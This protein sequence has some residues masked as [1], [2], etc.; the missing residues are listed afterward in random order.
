[1]RHD[2]ADRRPHRRLAGAVVACALLLAGCA[3]GTNPGAAP[4]TID[5]NT[6]ISTYVALRLAVIGPEPGTMNDSIRSAILARHG[7]TERQLEEFAKVH[8]SNVAYMRALWQDV[9]KRMRE[10]HPGAGAPSA[11]RPAPADKTDRQGNPGRRH[12]PPAR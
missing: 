3:G 1:M 7:V 8:G 10:T 4:A 11:P 9:E 2:L 12:A 6:F 5:R